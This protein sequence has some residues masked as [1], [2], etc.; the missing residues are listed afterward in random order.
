MGTTLALTGAH[1]LAGELSK[2]K[3]G[4]HPKAAF[5][6]YEELYKPWVEK[7]QWIPWIVPGVAH[8]NSA[9]KRWIFNTCIA[10]ISAVV[11]RVTSTPWLMSKIEA[12]K[13][14]D[15]I[16]EDFPLPHYPSLEGQSIRV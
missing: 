10:G 3:E 2:L 12:E 15:E 4:E 13:E 6:S 14:L 16:R 1:V 5:E 11:R 8:P 9:L 7:Q